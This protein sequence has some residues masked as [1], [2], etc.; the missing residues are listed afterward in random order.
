LAIEPSLSLALAVIAMV[1]GAVNAALLAGLV[2]DTAGGL[3]DGAVTVTFAADDI[4][5]SPSL[6]VATALRLYEPAGTPDHVKVYGDVVAVPISV[7][8][9]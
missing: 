7:E 3:F 5:V 8:P 9:A 1:A 6:S 2:I 4:V